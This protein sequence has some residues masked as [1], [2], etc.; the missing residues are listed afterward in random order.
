M[1]LPAASAT[2]KPRPA[3]AAEAE[4]LMA[5][6][7]AGERQALAG[8]IGLYGRGVRS[9]CARALHQTGEA[10]DAAQEVFLKLWSL[11][12]RYDPARAS[13]AT[14][15]YRIALSQ[16]QDRNRRARVR[17]FFGLGSADEETEDD[18]PDALRH[19][20]ARQDLALVR[21]AVRALPERQRQALLLRVLAEMET[22]AIAEVMGTGTGAVE[23][24][25]VRARA[26]LRARTGLELKG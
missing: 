17:Q 11:A 6:M 15:T 24:L 9:Y 14:W 1:T 8:L 2:P 3:H 23:Q 25:L 5:R 13:V 4:A 10:E 19:L 16:C 18:S 22:A 12:P 7:A 26:T 21:A 20:A